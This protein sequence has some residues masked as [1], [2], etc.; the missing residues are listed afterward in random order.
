MENGNNFMVM[1]L[2]G[3]N[4]SHYLDKN[5]KHFSLQTVILVGLQLLDRIE[6]LHE[7]G[8]LHRDIKPENMM[9]GI[10]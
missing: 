1:D 4:L 6:V 3:K 10:N 2:L 8:F 7:R 9:M 5:N